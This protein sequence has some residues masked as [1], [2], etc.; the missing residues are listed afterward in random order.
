MAK[1]TLFSW[2]KTHTNYLQNAINARDSHIP[3]SLLSQIR[4]HKDVGQ[5][6]KRI[7]AGWL[8]I[9]LYRFLESPGLSS[10]LRFFLLFVRLAHLLT[11][12]DVRSLFYLT[13]KY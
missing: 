3:S 12:A 4:G 11:I 8:D 1:F 6:E 10:F 13:N 7:L 5:T 2:N 9:L